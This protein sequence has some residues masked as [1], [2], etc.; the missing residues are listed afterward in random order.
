MKIILSLSLAARTVLAALVLG[1]VL[2]TAVGYRAGES[3][4]LTRQPDDPRAS[5][6]HV[7]TVAPQRFTTL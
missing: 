2:G 4:V 6:S 7:D 1:F 5:S 3:S